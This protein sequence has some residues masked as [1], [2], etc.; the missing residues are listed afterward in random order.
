MKFQLI[1][2]L[3]LFL[4]GLIAGVFF[5]GTFTVSPTFYE[6]PSSIHLAFRTALMNHNKSIVMGLV[7]AGM[8]SIALYAWE[9]RQ[10][11]L[12]RTLCL[13]AL[14]LTL[15]SLLITRLG[16]VPIN[17]QIKTWDPLSPPENWLTILKRWDLYN[18]VR[19]VT[20]I[21]SFGCL[22]LAD[23]WATKG[24]NQ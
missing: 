9:S 8:M 5:Y 20:S 12:V 11:K 24:V 23:L 22:L 10:I 4:T 2:I 6:V 18:A 15:F 1:R 14:I 16:S 19:T 13:C 17:L 3:A 7:L 21:A